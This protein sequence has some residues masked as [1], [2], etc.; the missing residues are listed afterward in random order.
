M[1]ILYFYLAEAASSFVGTTLQGDKNET[2]M[3]Y[4]KNRKKYSLKK[5]KTVKVITNMCVQLKHRKQVSL[6]LTV[7]PII[8]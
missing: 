5:T 4:L 8:N 3:A 6:L 7:R 2:K 1:A